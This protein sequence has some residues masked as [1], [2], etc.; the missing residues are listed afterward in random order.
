MAF[1]PHLPGRD[2]PPRDA[3]PADGRFFR[4]VTGDPVS[5]DDFLSPRELSPA[6]A[7]RPG[8]SECEMCAISLFR[9]ADEANHLRAIV[10]NFSDH[11][12]AE[13]D[14]RPEDGVVQPTGKGDDTHT[15]YWPHRDATPWHNFGVLEGERKR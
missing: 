9:T 14:L 6:R 12:I 4:L 8:E 13:G 2:C 10:R 3:L 5:A 7:L 11:L 15:E 1:R